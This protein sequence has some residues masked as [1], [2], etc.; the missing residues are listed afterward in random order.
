MTNIFEKCY[1][2]DKENFV[3]E[4]IE[5]AINDTP[6]G[7]IVTVFEG[8]PKQYLAS[9]FLSFD[10]EDNLGENACNLHEDHA[11]NWP[12]S[13][14]EQD[15]ELVKAMCAVVDEWATRHDLHPK[16]YG[17]ENITSINVKVLIG[18]GN[19]EILPVP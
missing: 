11:D 10:P 15:N 18:N 6:V 4:S 19:F 16:F 8:H 14:G 9:D 17:V 12:N 3:F 1:S 2:L 13:T 7:D 5:D